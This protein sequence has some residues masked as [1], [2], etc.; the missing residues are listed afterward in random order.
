MAIRLLGQEFPLSVQG[1]GAAPAGKFCLGN[2]NSSRSFWPADGT[3][4]FPVVSGSGFGAAMTNRPALWDMVFGAWGASGSFGRCSDVLCPP[5]PLPA[6]PGA[7]WRSAF[8]EEGFSGS[9]CLPAGKSTT[10]EKLVRILRQVVRYKESVQRNTYYRAEKHVFLPEKRAEKHVEKG[11]DPQPPC[12]KPGPSRRLAGPAR[13]T[14]SD[15]CRRRRSAPDTPARTGRSWLARGLAPAGR[16][17][18]PQR[19]PT[20]GS[21]RSARTGR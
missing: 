3:K 4:T 17:A 8:Y 21:A 15:P 11:P 20:D 6:R 18:P 13:G 19:S 14:G 16:T 1:T 5:P 12:G 10:T 9:F 2:E 7:F